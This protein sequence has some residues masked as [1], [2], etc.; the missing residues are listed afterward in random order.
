[1]HTIRDALA[2]QLAA[3]DVHYGWLMVALAFV[4]AVFS[5]SA[6]G[7][8]SVLIVPMAKELGWSIGELS[9]PQG[10]RLALF[11]LTAPFAGGLML[12]YGPTRMVVWSGALLM[13]GLGIAISTTE[14]WQLWLGMGVLLGIAPGLTAMQLSAVIASR[15]FVARRGLVIGLLSGAL[16]TGTLI[17]M[18]VAAFASERWGWRVA[19]MIPSLGA[20][21]SW[22]LFVWLARDRP[23]DLGLPPLGETA[24]APVPPVP[25]ANFVQLTFQ[26][27]AIGVRSWMFWVLAF[28]F[29]ICGISSF[30]L[31]QAHFVP[32]CGDLGIPLGTSAWMLALIGVCDLMG[33]IGSGWLS[34]RYD[35]RWLL[36]W[37]Y[38]MRGLALVWL[39]L[40]D[41]ST[42]GLV[43]FSV[44]YGLDFIA[45]VPPSVRLTVQA[46]GRE[47][48]PAVFAWIFAAH[49]V[50]AGVMAF[51]TGISRDLIGSYAPAF[52]L[53]GVLC[54]VA[55]AAFTLVRRP[56]LARA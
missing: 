9:A 50:A 15:W 24:V 23:Q 27:L 13:V 45:T 12:R 26:A 11:G 25:K 56:Q 22:L 52:L 2:R 34:D 38:G 37:Y 43:I 46:F 20:L 54:V 14:K 31:T 18:P 35:N 21:L 39:V 6:M 29:A 1:M 40:A 47:M 53:A 10:L 42:L 5:S 7:V 49:H 36:A 30:G 33:T 32:F 3:R 16:A 51:G 8:P 41:V 55:A 44:I 4:Y 19:L 28:T 48:G 17:F